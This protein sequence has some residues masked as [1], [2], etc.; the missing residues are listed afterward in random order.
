MEKMNNGKND[1][2]MKE[3]IRIP[4]CNDNETSAKI[5]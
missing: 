2:I 3:I 1:F 4:D 5:K